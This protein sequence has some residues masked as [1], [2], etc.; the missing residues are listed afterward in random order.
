[1]SRVSFEIE[2]SSR[3]DNLHSPRMYY[4]SLQSKDETLAIDFAYS[5][6]TTARKRLKNEILRILLDAK[7]NKENRESLMIGCN[8]GTVLFVHWKYSWGYSIAGKNKKNMGG[9][10]WALNSFFDACVA[11][12]R[13]AEQCYNG[14][15]WKSLGG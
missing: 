5:N 13:H 6:E 7:R 3:K 1:M 10:T 14:V 9:G 8:D 2:I 4:A 11:A 15:A 12:T